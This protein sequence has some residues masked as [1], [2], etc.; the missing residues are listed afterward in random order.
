MWTDY[1]S[2]CYQMGSHR[3][4][5][6]RRIQPMGTEFERYTAWLALDC[7]M[8]SGE[9]ECMIPGSDE[10]SGV[11]WETVPWVDGLSPHSFARC[12]ASGAGAADSH[13]RDAVS[14]FVTHLKSQQSYSFSEFT[15]GLWN[16]YPKETLETNYKYYMIKCVI[17][18]WVPTYYLINCY[19]L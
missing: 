14:W 10:A 12:N 1:G 8:K 3:K 4:I 5:V 15:C 11:S 13:G 9:S 16:L 7:E 17:K 2:L 18:S 19:V 6:A